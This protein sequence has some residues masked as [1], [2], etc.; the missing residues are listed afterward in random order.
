[1]DQERQAPPA[2]RPTAFLIF[3]LLLPL[4][5]ITFLYYGP[6]QRSPAVPGA[7]AV[8]SARETAP[9]APSISEK[10][11]PHLPP[12]AGLKE[13]RDAAVDGLGRVWV[14]DF[15]NSRLRVFDGNGGYLGGWG[16]RGDGPYSFKDLC[17]VAI[18][19]T[20]VYVADTW[21]GRVQ[22][23]TLQGVWKGSA[24]GL[25]GPRGVAVAADGRVWVSDTGNHRLVAYDPTLRE[26]SAVG[27][28]GSGPGEFNSPV[29]IAVGP[30]GIVF[31]ADTGNRRVVLLERDG[32]YRASWP[33]PGWERP[34]EPHVE[35][36][37]DGT[38]YV[39]DPG[40]A[41]ALLQFDENG[42]LVARRTSDDE[43][44]SFSLPSGIAIDRSNRI[45][46]VVNR[47]A[48][49]I[50]KISLAAETTR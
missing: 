48:N 1:M 31:V 17:G 6:L 36:D 10:A 46:Y 5:V 50:S 12:F 39:T 19:G 44:R 33:V 15:G 42:V 38:V 45:L 41:E 8:P 30:S 37:R 2:P 29:G 7:A 24:V 4:L 28:L 9:T 25:T 23:F 40:V 13:P 35:V 3:L 27:R 11:D 16:G 26:Q 14:A 34:V 32:R 18:Q 21:N 49:A 22:W 43:S 20:D 47:G